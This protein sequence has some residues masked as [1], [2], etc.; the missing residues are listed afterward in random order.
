[1]TAAS[2][3]Y[4]RVEFLI[5][6]F[7]DWIKQ[8]RELHEMRQ[9][10]RAD[11]DRIAGDLRVTPDDL[12]ELVR[13]GPHAADELPKLLQAL[14]INEA[15]LARAQ[16]LVLRDMERVC[17]MCNHKRECDRDLAAGTAAEHYEDY[18][19]NAPTIDRLGQTEPV[20]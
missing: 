8:R 2:K 5:N 18:C 9:M 1:M 13:K 4:P 12:E 7:A 15:S 17:A 16:P 11:F 20:K 3:P 14:G 10:D 19:N 6:S